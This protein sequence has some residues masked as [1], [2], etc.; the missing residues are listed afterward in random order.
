MTKT[1]VK[2]GHTKCWQKCGK[3]RTHSTAAK[4]NNGIITG[5]RSN[6]KAMSPSHLFPFTVKP[7]KIVYI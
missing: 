3:T 6:Y 2:T 4:H 1:F 5:E 7:L